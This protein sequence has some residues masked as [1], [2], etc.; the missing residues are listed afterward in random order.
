M[1]WATRLF[2]RSVQTLRPVRR[3]GRTRLRFE[4]LEA[5]EVPHVSGLVFIDLNQDGIQDV[6]DV[7]VPGVTVRA[8]DDTGQTLTATTQ[9]DGGYEIETDAQDVRLEFSGF[10]EGTA[11]GRV[12]G[13]SGPV[14][15]F[16][17]AR[18]DRTEVNLSLASPRLVTTQFFYDHARTGWNAFEGAVLA[19][20]YG[21]RDYVSPTVL[22][23][24]ADVGSVW[25]LAYQ[26]GSN[27][28]YASA[29]LKRHAG[30]GPNAAG[31]GVTTGGI[32]RIN[33]AA[34]EPGAT[35]LVDLNAAGFDTGANPH[36]NQN[37]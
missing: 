17:D 1:R 27:T 13:T 6:D 3:P 24:V 36:P 20:P 2:R 10:P 14:V 11:P 8:T 18:S 34:E 22:A 29:F 12:V 25:G 4:L 19:F 28:V 23:T 21:S 37:E 33:P 26:S 30:F 32:Y 9:D 15:R 35:L 5:R 7:G 16:L 31:T